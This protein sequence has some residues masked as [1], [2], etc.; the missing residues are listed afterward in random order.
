MREKC[1]KDKWRQVLSGE[2]TVFINCKRKE[3]TNNG[4]Y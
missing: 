3:V 1:D 4:L 2:K